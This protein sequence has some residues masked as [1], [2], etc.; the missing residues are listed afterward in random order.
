MSSS[1]SRSL[2]F[3]MV[4]VFSMLFPS[5]N[6]FSQTES[7]LYTFTDGADGGGPF[8][9]L[10]FDSAGNLY[11]DTSAGGVDN[12]NGGLGVVFEL[13]PSSGAWTETPLYA[14]QGGSTDGRVPFGGV[15]FDSAGNL[16]GT[17]SFGGTHDEGT[18]FE[19]SP[20]IGGGWTEQ[21]IY[22]FGDR[23]NDATYPNGGLAID[24]AGHL[25][26]TSYAGGAN[27]LGAVFEVSPRTGGGWSET[28]ILSGTAA[29]GDHF[30]SGVTVVGHN[31]YVP[32]A[33]GGSPGYGAIYLLSRSSSGWTATVIYSFLGGSDGIEPVGGLAFQAP[34][35]IFGTTDFGGTYSSGTAFELTESSGTWTKTILHNFGESTDAAYPANPLTIG[36]SGQLYGTAGS[37]GTLG[38]G[39]AFELVK[40]DGVW[41]EKILHNFNTGSSDV[42]GPAGGIVLDSSGNL[43]GMGHNGGSY[44]AG[45]IYE[46]VP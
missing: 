4:A 22:N 46:I 2:T 12:G 19:L 44:G 15:V 21:I 1:K 33:N 35:R 31:L 16:Y 11:G 3:V 36:P 5:A 32:A 38:N 8:G 13:S 7:V 18:V 41:K 10:I 23:A 24:S 39:A 25:Y 37:G 9:G 27:N 30:N 42:G 34:G 6:A 14:F 28:V 20:A 45:G 29:D 26:G 17:T 43:Y 40:L